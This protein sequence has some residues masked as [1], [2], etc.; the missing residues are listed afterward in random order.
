MDRVRNV[1]RIATAIYKEVQDTLVGEEVDLGEAVAI[2]QLVGRWLEGASE[3]T[4]VLRNKGL[5]DEP[6]ACE[7]EE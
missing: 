5:A 6:Y 7:G 1:T 4:L 3:A 2:C